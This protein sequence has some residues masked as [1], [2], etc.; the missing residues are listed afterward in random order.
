MIDRIE[1][2]PADHY[3]ISHMDHFDKSQIDALWHE[4]K[5]AERIVGDDTSADKSIDRYFREVGSSPSK[6]MAFYIK[7]FAEVNQALSKKNRLTNE[8]EK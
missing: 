3:M 7:C 8:N 2:Y 4:L 6:D 5:L 1:E